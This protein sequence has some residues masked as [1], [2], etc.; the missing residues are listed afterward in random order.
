MCTGFLEIGLLG[1]TALSTVGSLQGQQQQSQQ[2]QQQLQRESQIAQIQA[3]FEKDRIRQQAKKLAGAQRVAAVKS[4]VT[5]SGSI[6]EVMK[7]SAEDAE[8]AA[9]QAQYGAD[10][11]SE[12]RRIEAEATQQ[13]SQIQS[14][15]TLLS[16][17]ATGLG[18]FK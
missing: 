15:A 11:S 3:A 5:E 2:Q 10:L 4:G 6:T 18:V 17:L 1:A 16:G 8:L 14:Q 9:L 7:A 13:A 12:S